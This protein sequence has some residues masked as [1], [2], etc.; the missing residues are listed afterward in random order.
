MQD[1]RI[2]IRTLARSPGYTLVAL[3]TLVLGIGANTSVFSI[4][5]GV[6]L[7]PLGFDAEEQ[8]VSAREV[9]GRGRPMDAAWPNFVDWRDQ[10]QSFTG[11]VAYSSGETTIL[12]TG[13]PLRRG[14]AN[15]SEGFFRTL[16][17]EPAL[18]RNRA[19]REPPGGNGIGE[20]EIDRG[21][22]AFVD[23]DLRYPNE[24]FGEIVAGT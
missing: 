4:V 24:R 15:V 17:A 23:N 19:C 6:L 20:F 8:L 2:A 10:S 14:V 21:G 1:L 11:L 16:R 5:N 13:E 3:I 7:S 12:G 22:A 9:S 18:G